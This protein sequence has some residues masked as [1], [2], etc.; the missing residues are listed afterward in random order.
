MHIM[1]GFLPVEQAVGWT[2]I[3]A[4]FVGYGLV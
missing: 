3:S 1:E 4:P 2:V